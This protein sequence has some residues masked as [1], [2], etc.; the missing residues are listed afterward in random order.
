MMMTPVEKSGRRSWPPAVSNQP[1]TPPPETAIPA[2]P[3]VPR[4]GLLAV[5][6]LLLAF[7]PFSPVLGQSPAVRPEMTAATPSTAPCRFTLAES[8]AMALKQSMVV[9]AAKEGVKGAEA[10]K[11]EAFTGFLPKLSTSYSY[12]RLN[13][14]PWTN[15]PPM[16]ISS[17][18]LPAPLTTPGGPITVGTQDNY[19]WAL[20]F[21]Q[22]LFAGGSIL[23]N[24]QANRKGEDIARVDETAAA[25][26]IVEEVK[27][28]YFQILKAQKILGVARQAV[29]QLKSH[30]DEARHF[31]DVGLIP[32]NDLL[33]SEVQ[34][35]NGEH[36]LVRAENSLEI[37]K[38]RFNT[39][40]RRPI[41]APV[42][43]ED[44]LAYRPFPKAV[45]ECLQ[46]AYS[47]R[48][49]IKAHALKVEQAR[50]VVKAARGNFFPTL[51]AV[52]HYERFGDTGSLQGSTY[53]SMENWYLMARADWTFWEWGKTKNQ[54]DA[55]RARENQAGS[56][57]ILERDKVTLEVKAAY[58]LVR[59]S[60][61]QVFVAQKS[62]DQAEENF[63]IN[64]ERYR[65]QVAT[66]TDVLD[67][68]TLLT[69]AKSDYFTAL[70]DYFITQAR[71]ERAMGV[72]Q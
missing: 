30:R 12:T 45:E 69:K 29:E 34:L 19:S 57:L 61:K 23:A 59:E 31:F 6:A 21:R 50:E 63:R 47:Q 4:F 16:T 18:I 62:I 71:L 44:I 60:E 32:K 27:S 22:P 72:S 41:D 48:P 5:V 58:I 66:S 54:V 39:L 28:A 70:G 56:M 40:L 14:A 67:A 9:Q 15:M 68:Q 65:E 26:N 36:N 35:A 13:D 7:L 11:K 55:H 52:G 37:V 38:S 2:R 10:Q 1:V 8:V 53:K 20:E 46:T 17:P 24:Y 64:N 42:E 3:G 25:Q 49:E 51:S 43:V 33:Q